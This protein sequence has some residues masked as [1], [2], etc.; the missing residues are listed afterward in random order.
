MNEIWEWIKRIWKVVTIISIW[1]VIGLIINQQKLQISNKIQAW[2]II[3]L[4]FIT[5]VYAYHTRR[6]V[7]EEKKRRNSDYWAKTITEF[8][9]PLTKKLNDIEAEIHKSPINREKMDELKEDIRYFIWRKRY[10]VSRKTAEKI[11]N[12][13][14]DIWMANFEKSSFAFEQYYKANDEAR[15][16]IIKEWGAVE[17]KIRKIYA[18]KKVNHGKNQKRKKS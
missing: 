15:K 14:L 3:T 1:L 10:M 6:L 16:I 17:D 7:D 2:A 18:I 8:Y 11:E 5:G 13:L 12:L 9:E 4:V